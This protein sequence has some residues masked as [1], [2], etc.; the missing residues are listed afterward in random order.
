MGNVKMFNFWK[1]KV[2]EPGPQKSEKELATERGEPWVEVLNFDL[3]PKNSSQGAFELDWNVHFVNDLRSKGF[4]GKTDEQVVDN[5]FRNICRHIVLETYE[6]DV[7]TNKYIDR[8]DLG[9]GRTEVK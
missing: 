7:A 1:K 3:D 6:N 2:K 4:P 5:W 9:N 8:V